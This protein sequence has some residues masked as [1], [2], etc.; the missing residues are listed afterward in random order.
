MHQGDTCTDAYMHK[1]W[2]G[3]TN[4]LITQW[5]KTDLQMPGQKKECS[6]RQ[7][8]PRELTAAP[9]VTK[10][11]LGDL[12][13]V[14]LKLGNQVVIDG[15]V[16]PGCG[17][18]RSCEQMLPR[19]VKCHVQDLVLM[20]LQCSNAATCNTN[21]HIHITHFISWS[22]LYSVIFCSQAD[23][24]HSCYTQFW[25][26]D[27]SLSQRIFKHPPKWCPNSTIWFLHG[28]CHVHHI[29][30]TIVQCTVSL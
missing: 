10:S 16:T 23:L 29:P 14:T 19:V 13:L 9:W 1:C 27:C 25:M 30:C 15:V 6:E 28:W 11:H 22:L 3:R 5:R 18:C 17:V 26:S 7:I 21:T 4:T 12:S 2:L 20:A 24:L 8:K